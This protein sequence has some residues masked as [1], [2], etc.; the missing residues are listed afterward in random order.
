[1]QQ[2]IQPILLNQVKCE[3]FI[4]RGLGDKAYWTEAYSVMDRI[5]CP[6]IKTSTQRS[7]EKMLI[8]N[9]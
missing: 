8:R 5:S 9:G 1:M 4:A 7:L 3:T 6:M 2:F